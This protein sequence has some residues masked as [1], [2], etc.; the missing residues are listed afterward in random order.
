MTWNPQHQPQLTHSAQRD[1]SKI[2]D[3]S[4]RAVGACA[5]P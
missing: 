5:G 4:P 1:A 2:W 3:L